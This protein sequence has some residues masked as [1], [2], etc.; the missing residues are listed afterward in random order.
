MFRVS[1]I[2]AVCAVCAVCVVCV[3]VWDISQ[4]KSNGSTTVNH[5]PDCDSFAEGVDFAPD[6]VDVML[7]VLLALVPDGVLPL[8]PELVPREVGEVSVPPLE[9]LVVDGLEPVPV[10]VLLVT[11]DTM[12]LPAASTDDTTEPTSCR[13]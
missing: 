11:V 13:R 1:G 10:L 8:N 2:C 5:S 4:L 6:F 12:V 9:R 7:P 3:V